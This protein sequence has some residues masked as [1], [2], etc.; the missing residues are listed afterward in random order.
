MSGERCSPAVVT[1]AEGV[2][3]GHPVAK[4]RATLLETSGDP[5]DQRRRCRGATTADG[6]QA[7]GVELTEPWRVDQIPALRRHTDE[8]GDPF[9]LDQLQ[10]LLGVPPIHDHQLRLGHE[11]AHQHR[12]A[13]GDMEQR[14]D[15]DEHRGW[16]GAVA[17]RVGWSRA[18]RRR[19]PATERHAPTRRS[20]RWSTPR[21][22]GGPWCRRCT[23]WLR[24]RPN[25]R[26]PPASTDRARPRRPTGRHRRHSVVARVPRASV[27]RGDGTDDRLARCARRQ[28]STAMAP[29]SSSA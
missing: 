22:S 13:P 3:L 9:P 6:P 28:R 8:V 27:C 7:G 21:P 19:R 4:R 17:C 1:R 11:A 5:L 16:P 15:E 12:H 2:G 23:R 25:R 20:P 14:D 26:L 10:G 29:L 24:R 18:H